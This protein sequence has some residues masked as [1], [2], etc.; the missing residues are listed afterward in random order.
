MKQI[1][2]DGGILKEISERRFPVHRL[3]I[4][5][6]IMQGSLNKLLY[7]FLKQCLNNAARSFGEVPV[8]NPEGARGKI[9][10]E[11]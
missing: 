1:E 9:Q 7:K 11:I 8:K 2:D 10:K 3:R 6:K 5:K 4:F